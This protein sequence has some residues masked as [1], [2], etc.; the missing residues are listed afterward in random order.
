MEFDQR[1]LNDTIAYGVEIRLPEDLYQV[2]RERLTIVSPFQDGATPFW[3]EG[4]I[5]TIES[6]MNQSCD[7]PKE[8]GEYISNIQEYIRFLERYIRASL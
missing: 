7:T 2:L 4:Q 5:Q 8:F 1:F 3:V 6:H